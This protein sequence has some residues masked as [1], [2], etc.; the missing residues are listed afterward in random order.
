MSNGN[1]LSPK[2]LKGALVSLTEGFLSPIPNIIAFQ[3]NPE[4]ISRTLAPATM[5]VSDEEESTNALEASGLDPSAQ[6]WEPSETFTLK[7]E[8]DATD[9]LENPDANPVAVASGIADRIAALEM[10]L[11]PSEDV[12]NTLAAASVQG[13]AARGSV[14]MSLFI[15]GPGRA[16]PVRITSFQVEEQKFSSTLYPVQATITVELQVVTADALQKLKRPLTTG[17]QLAVQA[18]NWTMNQKRALAAE[19]LANTAESVGLLLPL[20]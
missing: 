17:E 12:A 11:Y 9:Q 15:W 7:I 4:T 20:T 19:N 13:V 3:Y 14:P 8:F 6:P 5:N 16:V 1:P 10:L 2:F 18:Y